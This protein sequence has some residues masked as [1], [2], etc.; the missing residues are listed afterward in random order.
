LIALGV[1]ALGSP[2]VYGARNLTSDEIAFNEA[3]TTYAYSAYLRG[4]WRHLDEVKTE[5]LPRA[6]LKDAA[7]KI[8]PEERLHAVEEIAKEQLSP[9][10]RVKADEAL[11]AALH[12]VFEKASAENTVSALREFQQKHPQA[13]D[14]PVAQQRIHALFQKT[15]A[16]FKPRASKPT[17][18]PFVEALLTY[19]EQ[20]A[21]PPLEVRFRRHNSPSLLLADKVLGQAPSDE[22]GELAS[23]S[24]HFDAAH[25]APR[26]GALISAMQRGFS[27]V[28]PA[29]VLPLV[30]GED[31]DPN[32][33]SV[34][35]SAKPTIFVDYTAGWSRSTY[36]NKS[37]RRFVGIVFDFDVVMTVPENSNRLNLH[38][39]VQ[40][41]DEFSV[42]YET[43]SDPSMGAALEAS[44][45][46][47]DSQV[48][49]VMSLRAFDQ[50]SSKIQEE[51]YRPDP[52]KKTAQK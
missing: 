16:D 28:F 37:G 43:F 25:A 38:F 34:S 17:S 48:Y 52:S 20:H 47:S 18:I 29:D 44:G 39:K 14:V 36:S 1:A 49:E 4:G 10:V 11:K 33:A 24:S 12:A 22:P 15:L 45:G 46:P 30:K 9:K 5:Y 32:D 35:A 42:H 41:P 6:Q 27:A 19:M 50:L 13:A 21:S 23:A 7:E 26:E 40:P 31:L 3:E 8:D 51:L 2:L